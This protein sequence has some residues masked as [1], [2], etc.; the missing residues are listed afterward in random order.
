MKDGLLTVKGA[1][2]YL[3]VSESTIYRLKESGQVGYVPISTSPKQTPGFRFRRQDLDA[4]IERK[5]VPAVWE[6]SIED[7][8]R[9]Y[10]ARRKNQQWGAAS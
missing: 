5:K 6:Q 9:K 4:W 10:G 1:A 3:A 8:L 2:E 7:D